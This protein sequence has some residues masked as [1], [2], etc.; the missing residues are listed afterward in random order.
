MTYEP[1]AEFTETARLV[2]RLACIDRGHETSESA[3]AELLD[4]AHDAQARINPHVRTKPLRPG[5]EPPV[6][7]HAFVRVMSI[8]YALVDRALWLHHARLCNKYGERNHRLAFEPGP[9]S[10]TPN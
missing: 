10:F 6:L 4:I 2:E 8:L 3:M 1:S 9:V 7:P 5:E